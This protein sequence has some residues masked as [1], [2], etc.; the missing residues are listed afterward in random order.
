VLATF[1]Q[2]RPDVAIEVLFA[3]LFD[4][5]GGARRDDVDLGVAA[6]P[7]D[8]TGLERQLL[9]T[10][11]LGLALAAGHPLAA[12]DAISVEEYLAATIFDFPTPDRPARE[13]WL[14]T[15]HRG[16]RPPRFVARFHS[17]D[18]LLQGVRAGL[19]VNLIRERIVD[20]L[21]PTSGVV[22]R[23]L[24]NGEQVEMTLAWR[25]GDER[26]AVRDFVDTC[27]V[28]FG[29]APAAQPAAPA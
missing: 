19:G 20:S 6:G 5:C 26:D 3:D 13:F 18:A 1:G 22:F 27:R 17:L 23:P 14:G 8:T 29:H 12:R 7:Y 11:P 25:S 9:W 4:A 10:E 15:R 16:G 21:G 24:D 28:A 2:R